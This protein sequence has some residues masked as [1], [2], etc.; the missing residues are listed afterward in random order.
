MHQFLLPDTYD[1]ESS[2]RLTGKD[3]HYICNVLR[4][5]SG[6]VFKGMDKKSRIYSVRIKDVQKDCCMLEL[7]CNTV[8][9]GYSCP[10]EIS[11]FQCLPKGQ[12]MDLIVRQATEAGV[13]RIIPVLSEHSVIRLKTGQDKSNKQCR[14]ERIAREAVQQ[15]ESPVCPQVFSPV[16]FN[17]VGKYIEGESVKIF[18]HQERLDNISLHGCL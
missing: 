3:Y 13:S 12:K 2:F 16:G 11:L 10:Y 17:E 18:F 6:A 9:R 15:S 8:E 4:L 7:S 14:W 1:G 5:N